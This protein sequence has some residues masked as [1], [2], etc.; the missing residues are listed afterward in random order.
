MRRLSAT[1][2][3]THPENTEPWLWVS[4]CVR[5]RGCSG[6]GPQGILKFLGGLP[7]LSLLLMCSL[8]ASCSLSTVPLHTLFCFSEMLFF[9]Q[10]STGRPQAPSGTYSKSIGQAGLPW[11]H[12]HAP[13]FPTQTSLLLSLPQQLSLPYILQSLPVLLFFGSNSQATLWA[14]EGIDS[15]LFHSQP[16]FQLLPHWRHLLFSK[17]INTFKGNIAWTVHSY[18]FIS[19]GLRE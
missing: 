14:P 18:S 8:H 16:Y 11:Q 1:G 17:L 5:M 19:M 10:V 4:I 9:P 7:L 15:D 3:S 2:R 12:F 6:C 13:L